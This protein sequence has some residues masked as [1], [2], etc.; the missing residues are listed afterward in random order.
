MKTNSEKNNIIP[1]IEVTR[2][3]GFSETFYRIVSITLTA[4]IIAQLVILII[5][6]FNLH[7]INNMAK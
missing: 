4:C 1:D 5:L 6:Y 7:I 2:M 3:F